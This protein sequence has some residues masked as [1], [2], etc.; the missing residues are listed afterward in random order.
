MTRER[1]VARVEA[2]EFV[3][4]FEARLGSG[5]LRSQEPL[6][7]YVNWRVGGPAEWFFIARTRADVIVAV[8]TAREAGVPVTILGY[9]ANVLVSDAGVR[10]LVIVNRAEGVEIRGDEIWAESG[11][12]LVA[13]A[14]R[15]SEA[16]IGGFEF[17]VG[18]PGTLGGGDRRQCRD[19]GGV[20]RRTRARGGGVG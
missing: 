20:D 3:R 15:A 11:M 19:A 4:A 9:G 18:I 1:E 8:R 10:G 16:G 14:R 6:A 5:R 12:N 13:L 7:P 17:L 2:G